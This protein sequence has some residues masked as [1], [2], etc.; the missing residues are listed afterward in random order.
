MVGTVWDH[1]KQRLGPRPQL[2]GHDPGKLLA[3][4]HTVITADDQ[5]SS[6]IILLGVLRKGSLTR[7]LQVRATLHPLRPFLNRRTIT[8]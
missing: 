5:Q 7:P 2:V 8:N 6:K 1:R 4:S 3:P